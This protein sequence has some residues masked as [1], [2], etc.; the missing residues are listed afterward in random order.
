MSKVEKLYDSIDDVE[1]E[2]KKELRNDRLKDA[3]G[4]LKAMLVK[5]EQSKQITANLEREYSA[6]K[7]EIENGI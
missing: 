1:A 4:K 7:H 5:I 2:A 3:K 6:L